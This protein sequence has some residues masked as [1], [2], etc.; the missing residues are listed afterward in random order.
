MQEG[1]IIVMKIKMNSK[2]AI[3]EGAVVLTEVV[4][5]RE[6]RMDKEDSQKGTFTI[7]EILE[8]DMIPMIVRIKNKTPHSTI[9]IQSRCRD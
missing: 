4:T 2:E 6:A 7:K 9:V 1:D 8:E 3:K 5:L